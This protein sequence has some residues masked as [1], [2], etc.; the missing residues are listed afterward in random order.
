MYRQSPAITLSALFLL[1]TIVKNCRSSHEIIVQ[2]SFITS[3]VQ[4]L[5]TK[6]REPRRSGFIK[7]LPQFSSTTSNVLAVERCDRTLLLIKQFATSFPGT[8][9]E[10]EYQ[11][12]LKAGCS[13]S[14]EH[15]DETAPIHTPQARHPIITRPNAPPLPTYNDQLMQQYIDNIQML[16]QLVTNL[17]SDPSTAHR[18]LEHDSAHELAIVCTSQLQDV[19]HKIQLYDTTT[20][21]FDEGYLNMLLHV[22]DI[23]HTSLQYYKDCCDGRRRVQ[24]PY[25]LKSPTTPPS[26][27]H[28]R[29][30]SL[31]GVDVGDVHTNLMQQLDLLGLDEQAYVRR[32][33]SIPQSP[34]ARPGPSFRLSQ[35][36]QSVDLDEPALSSLPGG[37]NLTQQTH[38]H[39]NTTKH[40]PPTSLPQRQVSNSEDVITKQQRIFDQI[41]AER[42]KAAEATASQSSSRPTSV[43]P[44][45]SSSSTSARSSATASPVHNHRSASVSPM[46]PIN[47]V[48]HDRIEPT[49][50]PSPPP[51]HSPSPSPLGSE[52]DEQEGV[53]NNHVLA[54]VCRPSVA[55]EDPW[56]S[57]LTQSK[58]THSQQL[59]AL[60]AL[61]TRKTSG[62]VE[63]KQSLAYEAA[64]MRKALR[65]T[66]S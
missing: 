12:L 9:C 41:A 48:V 54:A 36:S 2:Q 59:A 4:T 38:T 32:Q 43:P 1:E 28:R 30:Y 17:Q 13:F 47:Q 51:H 20:E 25:T 11:K 64:A 65:K 37:G 7:W 57:N 14:V 19:E 62:S 29:Q 46:P 18:V 16:L 27:M 66:T 45:T 52:C 34:V 10:I 56:L 53:P 23:H 22:N 55:D 3:L 33:R 26:N 31:R 61:K 24:C 5:P 42:R 21:G 39:Q 35:A 49:P 58:S 50:S 63:R 8:A 60:D 40:S 44:P 6:I 15:Q